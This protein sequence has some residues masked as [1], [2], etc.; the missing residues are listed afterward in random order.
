M[1][2]AHVASTHRLAANM[3]LNVLRASVGGRASGWRWRVLSGAGPGEVLEE[4]LCPNPYRK[5][6]SGSLGDMA[7]GQPGR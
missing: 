5:R 6:R 2:S 3:A 4:I 7:N 1:P